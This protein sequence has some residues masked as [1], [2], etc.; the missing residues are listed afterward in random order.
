MPNYYP[1]DPPPEVMPSM[2]ER[3]L[4]DQLRQIGAGFNELYDA[5]WSDIDF[6][7]G[8]NG[9][10]AFNASIYGAP[11]AR[12]LGDF[13]VLRG[14]VTFTS[15]AT[16]TVVGD[17][18]EFLIPNYTVILASQ[19]WDGHA[20]PVWVQGRNQSNPGRITTNPKSTANY[21]SLCGLIFPLS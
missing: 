1:A 3:Y 19:H 11:G 20:T 17:L 15:T 13:V 21:A 9:A 12:K 4:M 5:Q 8:T 14:L 18:P 16:L 10:A 7:N 2:L 6:T